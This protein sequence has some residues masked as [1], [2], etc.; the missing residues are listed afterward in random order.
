MTVSY[1]YKENPTIEKMVDRYFERLSEENER[2]FN[3]ELSVFLLG[4]LS[5]GEG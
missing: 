5:R 2:E 3:G 4:S 1:F